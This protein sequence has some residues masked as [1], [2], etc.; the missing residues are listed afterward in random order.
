MSDLIR[1]Y[2]WAKSEVGTPDKW[3]GTLRTAVSMMLHSDFPM[4][5][6]WGTNLIQFY[7]DA[8]RP[9]LGMNGKHPTALGQRGKD[10]WPEI[11]DTIYPL[12]Q[13]VQQTRRSFFVEDQLI[14]IYRNGALEDVYWTFSY[15][16][17]I[18]D[19]GEVAGVFVVCNETTKHVLSLTELKVSKQQQEE[20]QARMRSLVASA[21]FPIAVYEG[22]EMRIV[23]ANQAIV[24]VWGKG[25]E[26][27]GNTYYDLL[28]ELASQQIYPLLDGVFT[29]GIPFNAR[30]QRV[31]L[32]VNGKLTEFYFNYSFTPLFDFTGKVYGVLNTAADVTDLNIA[33]K[34][35]EQSE[36][37]FRNMILQAPVAMCIMIGPDHIVEIA[38]DLMI[39][40]WGKPKVMVMHRPIFDGL[41]DAREQGLEKLLRDVY[42]TGVTFKASERPVELVR[43]GKTDIVYQNFVYEPYRD[44]DGKILGVLAI[45]ID[46]TD[47]VI[48][49][50]QIEDIVAERTVALE[51]SNKDLQKSNAE[52]AQFAYIASHDLQE[53][54]RK[55]R[56]F[57]QMLEKSLS[58]NNNELSKNYLEKIQTSSRRMESLIR[59]VL[60]Y[61]EIVK[62]SE[63][64]SSV[65][66]NAIVN[67]VKSDFEV[68]IEQ[69]KAIVNFDKLPAIEAIQLQ[70]S[71]LFSNLISNA[72]KFSRPGVA[73][74]VNIRSS[75]ASHADLERAGLATDKE[76]VH[77]RLS[78]NG[79]GFEPEFAESIFHIFQR[80][81]RKSEFEGTGIGLAICKKIVV[82]H[83][84]S[85][86]AVGTSGEGAVFNIILPLKQN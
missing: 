66:L 17:V 25:E 5:L 62:T 71:Q 11:W 79:I 69:K 81:H 38:N 20:N 14:P 10:C 26:W 15:S 50:R 58:N 9:S 29:T 41:P 70:M 36:E 8:Y 54:L 56:T 1:N 48:A 57:A 37:N 35:L 16:A 86:D 42:E 64:F 22:R 24:D 60:T 6:W 21:P 32:V 78:D 51:S 59:D 68:A 40:L 3:S 23:M 4:F 19:A 61:S 76:H 63:L 83:E 84:G 43:K 28:P 72:L 46:V 31:D 65:D 33:K 82:N 80:L 44:S 77:I 47:Q 67:D 18:N 55:I 34:R 39:E 49:R 73:P 85:I 30:N 7:N 2:D 53:P 74:V 45:T 75:K 13:Q 12:I 27:I 52:L